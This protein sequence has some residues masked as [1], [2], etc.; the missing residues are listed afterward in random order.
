[1]T[2]YLGVDVGEHNYGLA[3]ATGPLA[4]PLPPIHPESVQE[5]AS[6]ITRTADSHSASIVVLGMPS[7]K[8]ESL[9]KEL[10]HIL[11][12]KFSLQVVLHSESLSTHDARIKLREIGAKRSKLKNDHSYAATLILEDYLE[13]ITK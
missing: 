10:Q 7:G 13:S 3:V 8:I 12:D 6:I 4:T 2:T 11:T 9:V 1:M 5:A